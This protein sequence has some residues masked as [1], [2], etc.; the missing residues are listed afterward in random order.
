LVT[1]KFT[2]DK[3]YLYGRGKANNPSNRLLHEFLSFEPNKI[4]TVFR[5]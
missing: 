3:V 1:I 5:E 2:E 4:L